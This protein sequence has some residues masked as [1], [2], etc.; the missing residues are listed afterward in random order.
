MWVAIIPKFF[1]D[2]TVAIGIEI[3]DDVKCIGTGFLVGRK[4]D[5]NTD[6]Y[7]I[8]LI[9]NYHVVEKKD[10]VVVR[11]NQ[12]NSGN[13]RDYNI[14]LTEDNNEL[15]SKHKAADII[16]IRISP[17]FLKVNNSEYNWFALDNHA[18]TLSQ[19]RE[20]DVVEGCIVYSLGFP[21]N[22]IG[23]NRKT[24]I[25]RIGCISRVS[26]LFEKGNTNNEFLIDL[27]TLPG[28]SGAPVINRPESSHIEGTT[29]NSSSNLIGIIVGTIDYSEK[30]DV[31]ENCEEKTCAKLYEKNSGFAVVHPV[32]TI[33]EVVEQEYYRRRDGYER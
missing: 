29:H 28:N 11:F 12:K 14:T 21:I 16:A 8:Y 26:D 13:C 33:I 4:E 24:P 30:C 31:S 15:F 23:T 10:S 22:M 25:C 19:M 2:A 20:T 6:N 9:T 32:D 27:Q 5:D 7:T 17:D 1:F 18:L 3:E